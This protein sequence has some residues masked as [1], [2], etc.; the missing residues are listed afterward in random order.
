[1]K[2]IIVTGSEGFVGKA[3]VEELKRRGAE[4]IGIDR[5][6]GIEAKNIRKYIDGVDCVFHLA[7]QTSVFNKDIGGILYDNIET[8]IDVCDACND[9]GVK[10]VYASSSTANESNTTSMYGISKR[11]DEQYAACYNKTAT[12]VRLHN[13]YGPNPRKG[14]LLWTLLNNDTVTLYNNGANKRHFTYLDDA[15]NGLIEASQQDAPLV[16]VANPQQLTTYEF[17]RIVGLFK[18]LNIT[19]DVKPKERDNDDQS[20]NRSVFCIPLHYNTVQEG[21]VKVFK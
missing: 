16:N 13:V 20:L 4:V 17:A 11:F 15:V 8:F 14:T 2:K 10:L 12:G 5:K 3:L 19:L 1:M 9:N 21:V 18:P 6:S 7:A